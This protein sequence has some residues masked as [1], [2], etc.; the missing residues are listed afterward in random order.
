MKHSIR[1]AICMT[2]FLLLPGHGLPADPN[3]VPGAGSSGAQPPAMRADPPPASTGARP[4]VLMRADP[5]QVRDPRLVGKRPAPCAD[6]QDHEL[7]DCMR[8][9]NAAPQS[10]DCGRNSANSARCDAHNTAILNCRNAGDYK[11]CITQSL[12]HIEAERPAPVARP[13]AVR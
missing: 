13:A 1:F 2:G 8:N 11:A 10:I 9:S 12:P 6:K 5:P 7:R 3:M 4:P